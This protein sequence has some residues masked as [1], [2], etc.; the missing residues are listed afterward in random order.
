MQLVAYR[1]TE[2]NARP[3]L[4]EPKTEAVV[5]VRD[6]CKLSEAERQ[7][8]ARHNL[9]LR[10][11][12]EAAEA[13]QRGKAAALRFNNSGKSFDDIIRLICKATGMRRLEIMQ[14][15]RNKQVVF[16][17][18]AVCYW[19]YRLTT[20]SLPEI[21]RRL[22]GLDHTTIMHAVKAYAAKRAQMGRYLREPR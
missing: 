18:H 19:A 6:I 14:N 7:R 17:R 13:L 9:F 4:P 1:N 22:G 21:G 15:R 3:N 11:K 8:V 12:R 20:L 2:R 10:Q 16:A 5:T